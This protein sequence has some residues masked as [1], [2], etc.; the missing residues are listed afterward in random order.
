M[1]AVH[2]LK[3]HSWV[4]IAGSCVFV[5]EMFLSNTLKKVFAGSGTLTLSLLRNG[6]LCLPKRTVHS[7][8]TVIKE[9]YH[10]LTPRALESVKPLGWTVTIGERQVYVFLLSSP[11]HVSLKYKER[12][13]EKR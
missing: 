2:A 3:V 7:T 5:N 4:S 11:C 9:K 12:V 1:W 8:V 13:G 6:W 10:G